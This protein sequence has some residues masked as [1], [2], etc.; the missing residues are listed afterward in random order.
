MH[1]KRNGE[2]K[3][4]G[5]D[6]LFRGAAPLM[7]LTLGVL[8]VGQRRIGLGLTGDQATRAGPAHP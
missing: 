2:G 6:G 8:I 5:T 7:A 3:Q 1:V 4:G